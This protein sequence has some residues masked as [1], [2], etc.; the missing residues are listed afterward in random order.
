[1]HF[2][3]WRSIAP[4]EAVR[5]DGVGRRAGDVEG[6]AGLLDR[7]FTPNQQLDAFEQAVARAKQTIDDPGYRAKVVVMIPYRSQAFS[8]SETSTDRA[9]R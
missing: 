8:T 4:T 2:S 7:L 9:A 3:S 5:L 1:M 6:L